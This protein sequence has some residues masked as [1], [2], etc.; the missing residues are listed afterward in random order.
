MKTQFKKAF[1]NGMSQLL[2]RNYFL[3]MQ[4]R[5]FLVRRLVN[6][7]LFIV[8]SDGKVGSTTLTVSLRKNFPG[9]FVFHIHRLTQE[10][11]AQAESYYKNRCKPSMIPDNVI[12]SKFLQIYLK[13]ISKNCEVYF[14]SLV[15]D[16]VSALI[17]GYC[18]SYFYSRKKTSQSEDEIVGSIIQ[19]ILERFQSKKIQER[20]DWIDQELNQALD[21]NIYAE[22]FNKE[23]GYKIYRSKSL[24]V[25]K[26]ESF[27]SQCADAMKEFLGCHEF[28]IKENNKAEQSSYYPVYQKVKR[29]IKLPRET[30]DKIYTSK[31][32]E[33]FYTDKEI[34]QFK[35]RWSLT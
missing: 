14:F 2:D 20:L 32:V 29:S 18:Q 9:Q 19:N 35:E 5:V 26:L 8:Y 25:I 24:L 3:S 17:S 4:W 7:K 27:N 33:Y 31:Y 21:Y 30:L 12:Q 15:R 1:K 23:K 10:S 22:E 28:A 34:R 13:T 16:P 6:D 11:I